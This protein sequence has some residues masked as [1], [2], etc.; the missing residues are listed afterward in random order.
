MIPS[1]VRSAPAL[2][3]A[4]AD[5]DADAAAL[6]LVLSHAEVASLRRQLA[7]LIAPELFGE[8]GDLHPA[9]DEPRP[10]RPGG[11]SRKP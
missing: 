9:V 10:G 8:G 6:T 4:D 3:P 2:G 5:A 7:A 1:T 11:P